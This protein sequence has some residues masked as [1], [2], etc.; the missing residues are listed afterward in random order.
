[1]KKAILCLFVVFAGL[2]ASAQEKGT[3]GVRAGLN[4]ANLTFS[5][6]GASYSPDSRASFH[7]GF[8]YQA[9]V[10]RTHPLFVETGLYL[11]GRG[12]SVD[13]M[14]LADA[15]GKVK[16][17]M[18]YLQLPLSLSW[19][20]DIKNISLQP[21]VGFYYGL[22]IHGKMKGDGGE[23]GTELD[24]FKEITIETEEGS[25]SGKMLKRSDFGMRFGLGM[26]VQRHFYVG[27][28]YDLGLL[29]IA[30]ESDGGK[31]RNGS[32]F[33]SVGYNF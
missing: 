15:P 26:T 25:A 31:V 29:N 14:E 13:G 21:A 8:A 10:L 11:T 27:L 1:M 23:D 7:V 16:M 12:A 19:H 33:L 22:G 2:T 30:Y 24:M 5:S 28:G 32:F 17:N 20:F 9:P 4:V 18:L 6:G 3:F